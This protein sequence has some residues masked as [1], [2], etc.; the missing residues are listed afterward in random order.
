MEAVYSPLR[1]LFLAV[2]GRARVHRQV[3]VK[4]GEGVGVGVGNVRGGVASIAFEATGGVE[5]RELES[6]EL[7]S[8]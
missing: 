7:I 4:V 3:E 5:G 2:I 8:M 6:L 1:L